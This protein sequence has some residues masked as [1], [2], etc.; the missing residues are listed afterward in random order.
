MGAQE[1]C[2]RTWH[3]FR[4]CLLARYIILWYAGGPAK[5]FPMVF[6]PRGESP[7]L[8]ASYIYYLERFL[9][10]PV[11]PFGFAST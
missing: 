1:S 7:A 9:V 5:I 4:I 8:I 11:G 6:F 2:G 3:A 10:L